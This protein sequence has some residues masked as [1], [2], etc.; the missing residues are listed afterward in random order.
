MGAVEHRV[1]LVN[2]GVRLLT[3]EHQT[4]DWRLV[5]DMLRQ[6]LVDA[7]PGADLSARG[8]FDT[9]QQ[10]PRLTTVDPAPPGIGVKEAPNEQCFLSEWRDRLENFAEL[11]LLARSLGPPKLAGKPITRKHTSKSHGCFTVRRNFGCLRLRAPNGP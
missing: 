4:L 8:E 3:A 1:A 9:G 7:H 2:P 6:P 5:A 11:H 10:V